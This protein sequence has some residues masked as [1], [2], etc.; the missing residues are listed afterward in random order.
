[1]FN[2]QEREAAAANL[3]Q[4]KSKMAQPFREIMRCV[5][6][7]DL[8]EEKFITEEKL[9]EIEYINEVQLAQVASAL[10]LYFYST[11]ILQAREIEKCAQSSKLNTVKLI[12][13]PSDKPIPFKEIFQVEDLRVS[14]LKICDQ[15]RTYLLEKYRA[16]VHLFLTKLKA[17]FDHE[18]VTYTK[19]YDMHRVLI[20]K[21][22]YKAITKA[23]FEKAE[24]NFPATDNI[25]KLDKIL[26]A[27]GTYLKHC[28]PASTTLKK[29]KRSAKQQK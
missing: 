5:T 11:L 3:L 26:Y 14:A 25:P 17:K 7:S 6:P 18:L 8:Y 15:R 4:G 19:A 13:P 23:M 22:S 24:E 21:Y 12:D 20:E 28:H 1:M 2:L 29:I 10:I 16:G 9:E 27:V